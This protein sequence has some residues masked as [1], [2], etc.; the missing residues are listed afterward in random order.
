M[1]KEIEIKV[2]DQSFELSGGLIT[3]E[4]YFVVGE[5]YFPH[6]NWN[7]F[8]VV[9]LSWWIESFMQFDFFMGKTSKF[10]FMDGPYYVYGVSR[11]NKT[12]ELDF[13]RSYQDKEQLCFSAKCGIDQFGHALFQASK[14]AINCVKN[15]HWSNRDIDKL[16]LLNDRLKYY[17]S[18]N[19]S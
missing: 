2:N 5:N 13:Q 11:E 10:N 1:I 9:V 8:V 19:L 16:I 14:L 12:L 4:L 18:R 3:G 6:K 15:N 17:L 7:D